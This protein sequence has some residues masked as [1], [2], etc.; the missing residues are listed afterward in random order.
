MSIRTVR[1]IGDD[2]LRKKSKPVEE[3]TPRIKALIEDL[4]ETMYEEDGVGLAAPQIGILR[5]I[6]VVDTTMNEKNPER[7]VMINPEILETSG[8]QEGSEGCLSVP[9]KHAK[10]IR[11]RCVKVKALDEEGREFVVEAED[12]LARAILHEF[13][14]L[15]GVLYVDKASGP[16]E[17][18]EED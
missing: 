2:L 13:D 14:H 1:V 8:T 11:P 4:Y 3:I 12:L 5:R 18:N 16:I 9:G 10:V 15:E 17:D 6:F 7:Y